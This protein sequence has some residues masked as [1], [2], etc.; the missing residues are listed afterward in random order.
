MTE[1][2]DIGFAVYF[3]SSGTANNLAEMECVYPY[4]R[5][6]CSLVPIS[7]SMLC[8]QTG[9]YIIEFDNYYSW[10]SAKQLRYNI[11]IDD[12]GVN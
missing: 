3:D 1:E 11:E 6:E 7:G 5:L 8:E 2:E 9:R 4:I 10:F 12:R